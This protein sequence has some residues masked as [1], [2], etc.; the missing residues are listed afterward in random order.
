V[1]VLRNTNTGKLERCKIEGEG[2]VKRKSRKSN[3]A[4]KEKNQISE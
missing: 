1:T 4:K 3:N 2:K